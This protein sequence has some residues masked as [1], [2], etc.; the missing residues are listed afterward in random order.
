M[1]GLYRAA[2][3]GRMRSTGLQDLC[4]AGWGG[5]YIARSKSAI[6]RH[7]CPPKRTRAAGPTPKCDA[8]GL[9]HFIFLPAYSFICFFGGKNKICRIMFLKFFVA[10]KTRGM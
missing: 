1:E 3:G 7:R 2:A 8:Q 5:R 9:N 4:I 10:P 6:F